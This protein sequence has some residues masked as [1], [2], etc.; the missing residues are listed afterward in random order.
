MSRTKTWAIKLV[1]Y[2]AVIKMIYLG[3]K[4]RQ[5]H[6]VKLIANIFPTFILIS[7]LT[8]ATTTPT[9]TTIHSMVFNKRL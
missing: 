5:R 9:T 2:G 1:L 3:F 4:R 8:T 6:E 7:N